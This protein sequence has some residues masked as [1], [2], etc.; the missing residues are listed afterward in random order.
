MFLTINNNI[1]DVKCLLTQKDI[2]E[3]MMNK[4]FNGDF[5][6]LLFFMDDRD[7]SF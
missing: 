7:H 2:E 4:K 3:G 5:D 6:G 1:F